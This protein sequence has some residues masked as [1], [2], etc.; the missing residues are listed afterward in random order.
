MARSDTQLVSSSLMANMSPITSA[1]AA[2]LAL[3]LFRIDG[4]AHALKGERDENFLIRSAS[5]TFVLKVTNPAEDRDVT[6]FQTRALLHVAAEDPA[7]PVP[8][9]LRAENGEFEAEVRSDGETRIARLM[10]FLPGTMAINVA[11]SPGL[12]HAIG[13]TLARL[14]LA[15][16][17]FDHPATAHELSWDLKHATRLRH[18]LVHIEDASNRDRAEQALDGFDAVVV[19]MQPALREQVIHSD[20]SLF[21]ILVD[22]DQPPRILGV[23]DFGD[24]VH[25]P[26]I[27]DLA[28]AASYHF[29]ADGP[30]LAPILELVGAYNDVLLLQ[31]RETDL[32]YD[33]IAMR[34]AMTI[35]IT[36]WR[37]RRY[38][39]NRGYILKNHPAATLGLSRLGEISRE[40][41]QEQFRRISDP[42]A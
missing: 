28:I 8:R 3:R 18:L 35:L 2:T 27:N 41:A 9:L 14:D 42:K 24:L 30:P 10:T 17:A 34:M 5:G 12:R 11:P 38:P 25:A 26:L 32:L 33:L 37:A 6:A 36:E 29:A 1:E 20:L 19:P 31:T 4:T 40:A 39:E 16:A 7:L 21:N 23:I 22:P 13:Q 15:L